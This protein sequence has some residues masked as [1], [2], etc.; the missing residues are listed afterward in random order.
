MNIGQ[1]S[2][3]AD[4][5]ERISADCGKPQSFDTIVIGCGGFGSA[6]LSHLARRGLRVLGI[7]QFEP[8]HALGSSH[9]ETR[10]IRK[11]YFEHPDYVPLLQRAYQL[12]HELNIRDHRDQIDP[13]ATAGVSNGGLFV[14][15]GLLLAGP[16][17]GEVI[18]GATMAAARHALPIDR[19]SAD[20]AQRRFPQM[21]V[22]E[23]FSTVFERDAGF[24]W[25]ERCVSAHLADAVR[26][27]AQLAGNQAVVQVDANSSS[28]V[29]R[30]TSAT[31]TAANLVVTAGAWA[32]KLLAAHLAE[33]GSAYD[34]WIRVKRKTL[35]WCPITDPIWTDTARSPIHLF[36]LPDNRGQ[37]YGFP[38]VDGVTVKLAEH[39]GGDFIDSPEQLNRTVDSSEGKN[40]SHYAKTC[41][42]FVMPQVVRSDVCMYSMSP[43]GHFLLDRLPNRPIVIA[44]GFSGHGFKFTS[45]LGEAMADLVEFGTSSLP[46]DFLSASRL[47]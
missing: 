18:A 1:H 41:L 38:S 42:N 5:V 12:W 47:V 16:E 30:T 43:D 44:A 20:E 4:P 19:M 37:F 33:T 14:R 21:R 9:G 25:V 28:V 8:P 26:N 7:D 36:E 40:V 39:T 32:G 22:P 13:A 45:V 31:Y 29:V 11:A 27:G 35:F 17:N 46:I 24:L 34:R 3:H 6:A 2:S 23:S 15:C 10:V